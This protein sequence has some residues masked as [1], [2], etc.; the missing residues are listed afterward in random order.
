MKG[1]L[2]GCL[3]F[4]LS[5]KQLARLFCKN[6]HTYSYYQPLVEKYE[7]CYHCYILM[8]STGDVIELNTDVHKDT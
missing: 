5:Q 3:Q 2:S 4:F 1:L 7:M 6:G 8:T